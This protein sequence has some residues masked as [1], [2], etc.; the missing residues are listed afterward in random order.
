MLLRL[1]KKSDNDTSSA[2]CINEEIKNDD[3]GNEHPLKD[4]NSI[5]NKNEKYKMIQVMQTLIKNSN[6]DKYTINGIKKDK[7]KQTDPRI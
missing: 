4:P 5:K 3:A 7:I 2:N 6:Q 1:I